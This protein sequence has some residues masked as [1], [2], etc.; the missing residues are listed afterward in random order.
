MEGEGEDEE[1]RFR[2]CET[3]PGGAEHGRAQSTRATVEG[4]V[5]LEMVE[6]KVMGTGV[7][8]GERGGD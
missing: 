2:V 6:W 7:R 3:L 8:C 4:A 1:E 5:W